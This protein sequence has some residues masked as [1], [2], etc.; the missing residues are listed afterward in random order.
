MADRVCTLIL[1]S[2]LPAIEVLLL[3]AAI[4][5]TMVMFW[6]RSMIAGLVLCRTWPAVSFARRAELRDLETE[7]D[8]IGS[9]P[10]WSAS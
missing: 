7:R 1:S 9:R 10:K 4:G 5:A 8:L 6:Q 2:D 3:W